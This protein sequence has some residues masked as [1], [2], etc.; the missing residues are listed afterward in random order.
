MPWDR[1]CLAPVLAGAAAALCY[2]L[3]H[4]WPVPMKLPCAAAV[5]LLG[6]LA[7]GAITTVEL[8][9]LSSV[10]LAHRTGEPQRK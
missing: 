5:Y 1:R 10:L 2:T 6:A 7:F 9:S 8:R 3:L 4:S